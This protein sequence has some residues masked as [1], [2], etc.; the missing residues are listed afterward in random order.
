MDENRLILPVLVQRTPI[1]CY[2]DHTIEK[3]K[4]TKAVD[5]DLLLS[6]R[7]AWWAKGFKPIILSPAEAMNNPRYE[8]VQKL[9]DKLDPALKT[10]LMRWLAWEDMGGGVLAHYLLFPMGDHDDPLL[11]F[12]RRARSGR[13]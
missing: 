3:D 6:W 4:D 11:N 12:L 5:S 10:D 1:Y 7:R 2:Y 8:E 9:P 13:L